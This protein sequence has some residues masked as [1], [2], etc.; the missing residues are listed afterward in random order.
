MQVA[1]VS[2]ADFKDRPL[3]QRLGGK[4]AIVAMTDDFALGAAADPLLSRHFSGA[5]IDRMKKMLVSQ[6]C[7]LSGGPCVYGGKDM[8]AAHAGRDTGEP[9]FNAFVDLLAKTLDK[10]KVPAREKNELLAL[11]APV[12]KDIVTK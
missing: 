8:K 4:G 9:G 2:K 12:K 3:Y 6:I 1:C 10:F 5:D 11:L 7:A